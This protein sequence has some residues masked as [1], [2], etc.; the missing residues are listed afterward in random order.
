MSTFNYEPFV[1]K[2]KR[3]WSSLDLERLRMTDPST[4]II[5]AANAFAPAIENII[6]GKLYHN[7]EFEFLVSSLN[8]GIN[9]DVLIA[10]TP[11][12][13]DLSF[14]ASI[15]GAV[16]IIDTDNS[17]SPA[18]STVVASFSLKEWD[19]ELK[20]LWEKAKLAGPQIDNKPD[21]EF[22]KSLR[23]VFPAN[24]R[25]LF[26]GFVFRHWNTKVGGTSTFVENLLV[27]YIPFDEA[28]TGNPNPAFTNEPSFDGKL[29]SCVASKKSTDLRE[30][31]ITI[32]LIQDP[33]EED[34]GVT[35][36]TGLYYPSLQFQNQLSLVSSNEDA[37]FDFNNDAVGIS[38]EVLILPA[39]A[40][41][42]GN[43]ITTAG[44][45]VA[46]AIGKVANDLSE[47]ILS[48]GTGIA[49]NLGNTIK[50]QLQPVGAPFSND[51]ALWVLIKKGTDELS[52]ENYFNYMETVFCGQNLYDAHGE[53][54]TKA[55]NLDSRRSLPF[56]NVDAYRAV[57][58]ATEAFVM[59][60]CM[61]QKNFSNE[62][63]NELKA[64]V[65]LTDGVPNKDQLNDF[66]KGFKKKINGGE[67]II[68]YLA[69]IQRKVSNEKIKHTPFEDAFD[70]Y[71]GEGGKRSDTCYGM[72]AE[73][74]TNPCFLEL[75][76]SYW[77][78]ESMMVQG[79]NAVARRFQNIRGAGNDPLANL[80]IDPL[81]PLNNLMWGYIQDDQH[82][83]TVRRRTYEYDHHYG[84][85]LK[86]DAAKN[87]RFA[88]SRSKFIEAFHTLLNLASRFY[89]QSDDMTVRPDGFPILNGLRETHLILSEGAHNQYG[90]LPSTARAE[91]LMQ[92]WMLA[93][94][95]FQQFLPSREMV[96]YP[97][98][99]MPRV[100]ALNN[101]MGWNN[102][103]VLHF[104]YLAVF[105]EKILL[106][107]RFGNWA[108]TGTASNAAA[109][110][111][112]YWRP[113]IQ[114]YI[115]AY[116]AVTGVDLSA[117]GVAAGQRVD[118]QQPSVHLFRRL[119]EQ[120]K[121][122]RKA[123]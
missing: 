30:W 106:S 78:E 85:S 8:F 42:A 22:V 49:N 43:E 98:A 87:L 115:H 120:Q 110:W 56:M 14:D 54:L 24:A 45:N 55:R 5:M 80:E 15:Q 21:P 27:H 44:N 112:A 4:K 1:L 9:Q 59:V 52:F 91:M 40:D 63:I 6:K 58:V 33:E 123:A 72:I 36:D 26:E 61:V 32:K 97:E 77:T 10:D 100:A 3:T 109:N 102:T 96:A 50:T 99:W 116:R 20:S 118:A 101:M 122:T 64:R 90:D 38:H 93:R 23:T 57:K 107:I 84:I 48:I 47:T 74:L 71:L 60:N 18:V 53:I 70:Y 86:G 7:V 81:R 88:D 12:T 82:R 113:E 11:F 13:A 68:P 35:F 105:G 67:E 39:T 121:S 73:K 119:T 108:D 104:N 89:K 65:S 25:E 103:S 19:T 29:A 28:A 114:G 111:A 66:F 76:W 62:D 95:E 69:V 37:E 83:L 2:F 34:A 17:V 92:Q 75:I 94:P 51:M 16:S 41:T 31:Q 46:N 117:E 79:L